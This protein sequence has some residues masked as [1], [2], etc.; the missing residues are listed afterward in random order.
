MDEQDDTRRRRK[1]A[2]EAESEEELL[3]KMQ[4]L[5][6]NP[7][8]NYFYTNIQYIQND[9]EDNQIQLYTQKN[10]DIMVIGILNPSIKN[11]I[12]NYC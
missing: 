7:E 2:I 8:L 5:D 4:L 1:S 3:K 12:F 11:T 6:Q 9:I 10:I